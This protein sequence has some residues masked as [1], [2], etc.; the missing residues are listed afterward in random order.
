VAGEYRVVSDPA[1]TVDL[2]AG[3]RLP[4]VK[5]TLGFSIDGEL[6]PVAL[7]GRS[8]SKEVSDSLWDGIVGVK[9][10]CT[11]T[12]DRRWFLPFY[13]DVG[14]GQTKLAW[15]AVA[16]TGYG[17]QW[18]DLVAKYR[19]VDWNAK[20]R[21]PVE[22]LSLGG[23]MIGATWPLVSVPDGARGPRG[24]LGAGRTGPRSQVPI[25]GLIG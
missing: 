24:A 4:D 13:L 1:W 25:R 15:Q 2:L 17:F 22:S 19:Y 12:D 7:P 6:G 18:G 5:T 21:T 10:R 14:T 20:S 11:F 3:A 23:L 9:G 8:G 16:G